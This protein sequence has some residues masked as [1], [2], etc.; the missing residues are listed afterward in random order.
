MGRA[1]QSY[2][3]L[4]KGGQAFIPSQKLVIGCGMPQ[5]ATVI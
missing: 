2:H 5:E 1:S 4:G 3:K